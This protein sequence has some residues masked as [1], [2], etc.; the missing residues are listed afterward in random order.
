MRKCGQV[1]RGGGGVQFILNG[2][3]RAERGLTSRS[4]GIWTAQNRNVDEKKYATHPPTTQQKIHAWKL[5]F[6][7]ILKPTKIF[8]SIYAPV[9][10]ENLDILQSI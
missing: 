2:L 7:Q 4:S 1:L 10:P 9:S 5:Y 8:S 6:P 3:F